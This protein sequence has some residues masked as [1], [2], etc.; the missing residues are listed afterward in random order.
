M[1]IDRDDDLFRQVG[2]D[3]AENRKKWA[4]TVDDEGSFQMCLEEM[5]VSPD[6]EIV[7][8]VN[9]DRFSRK[10]VKLKPIQLV[11]GT[12]PTIQL[13]P[14]SWAVPLK[15]RHGA[16]LNPWANWKD[17]TN[18]IKTQV[19]AVV[20]GEPILKGLILDRFSN[21]LKDLQEEMRKSAESG[22]RGSANVTPK[23]FEKFRDEIIRRELPVYIQRKAAGST[24]DGGSDTPPPY[25]HEQ[26]HRRIV[27]E[28]N[29]KT[30]KGAERQ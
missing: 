16:R 17:D 1:W 25:S 13:E 27:R 12:L 5:V 9:A 14:Q 6:D 7:L 8:M 23:E 30:E 4:A 15:L 19:A 29:R 26:A 10:I 20:N 24:L 28:G 18:E 22:D 11:H 2:A 3:T 21:Y